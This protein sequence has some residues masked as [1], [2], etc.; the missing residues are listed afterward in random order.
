MVTL[1]ALQAVRG[2]PQDIDVSNISESN[3]GKT[4]SV[5]DLNEDYVKEYET[6]T[7]LYQRIE[8]QSQVPEANV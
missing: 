6:A 5:L 4:I 3:L 7:P 8:I 2:R 1:F